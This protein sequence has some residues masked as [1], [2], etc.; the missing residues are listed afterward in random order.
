MFVR[1]TMQDNH[2]SAEK[3]QKIGGALIAHGADPNLVRGILSDRRLSLH[4]KVFLFADIR[5]KL[6]TTK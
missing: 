4:E 5:L 3:I 1:R 6:M 2:V